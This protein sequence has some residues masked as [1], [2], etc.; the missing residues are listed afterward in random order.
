MCPCR[1]SPIGYFLCVV[2]NVVHLHF[3][4]VE[5]TSCVSHHFISHAYRP[6]IVMHVISQFCE[7][8][9]SF[10]MKQVSRSC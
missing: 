2:L 9:F 7:R 4:N 3:V 5:L 1:F 8:R 6:I 10:Y